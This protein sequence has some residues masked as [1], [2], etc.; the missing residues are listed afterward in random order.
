MKVVL[1][2][3]KS[4]SGFSLEGVYGAIL[5]E[6]DDQDI[7]IFKLQEGNFFRDILALR[8]LKADLYHITGDVHYISFFLPRGKTILTIHDIGVYVQ[9]DLEGIKRYIYRLIWINLPIFFSRAVFFSSEKTKERVHEVSNLKKKYNVVMRLCSNLDFSSQ[10]N[11]IVNEKPKILHVG[12][13]PH[14]NLKG[15]IKALKGINCQLQIVGEIDQNTL[16]EL[17]KNKI[18]YLNLNKIEKSHLE[19]LYINSD[20]VTFPS[21]HEGFGLPIIEAQAFSIPLITS[22]LSPMKEVASDGALLVDPNSIESIRK[23]IIKI[24]SDKS[25]A[26]ELVKKGIENSNLYSV[27]IVAREH[28]KEY[29]KLTNCNL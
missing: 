26:Q 4:G 19:S 10:E 17:N 12:T 22:N 6:L 14:K 11:K 24:L 2:Q 15:V 25:L 1:V 9:R 21:F 13:S 8:A 28:L 16:D 20:L 18:D 3:R 29:K 5:N 7:N 23:A 27:T